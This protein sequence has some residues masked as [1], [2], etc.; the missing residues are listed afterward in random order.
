MGGQ[1]NRS[2]PVSF[3]WFCFMPDQIRI[4]YWQYCYVV[5]KLFLF[6]RFGREIIFTAFLSLQLIQ[7]GQLSV[8]GESMGT[9]TG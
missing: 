3:G 9:L 8:T 2:L 7:V 4:I 5:I 1:A 6:Q